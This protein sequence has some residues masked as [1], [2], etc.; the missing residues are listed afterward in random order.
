M[1][2]ILLFGVGGGAAL[3][4][5]ATDAYRAT[6]DGVPGTFTAERMKSSNRGAHWWI[7]D[8]TSDD[9]SVRLADVRLSG[10]DPDSGDSPPSPLSTVASG[11]PDT[12]RVYTTSG[13]PWLKPFT[14]AV[15]LLLGC[16]IGSVLL[17]LNLRGWRKRQAAR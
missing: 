12:D 1:C 9:G 7:G 6:S 10:V 13:R 2:F 15:L 3:A 4:I 16:P 17:V 14:G 8:F 5:S 11:D